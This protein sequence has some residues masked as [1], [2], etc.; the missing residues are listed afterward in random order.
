MKKQRQIKERL[1]SPRFFAA[2]VAQIYA[3]TFTSRDESVVGY[4]G[5]RQMHQPSPMAPECRLVSD[6]IP[7]LCQP[8][9]RD[10]PSSHLRFVD[11][12]SMTA[13]K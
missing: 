5:P 11:L 12:F 10:R 9:L 4:D 8:P 7:N 1:P 6:W 2:T 3:T 13:M